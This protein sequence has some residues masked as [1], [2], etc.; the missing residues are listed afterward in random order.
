MFF[1]FFAFFTRSTVVVSVHFVNLEKINKW[2]STLIYESQCPNL[3]ENWKWIRK[4]KLLDRMCDIASSMSQRIVL[5]FPKFSG[6]PI[7]GK[8][9]RTLGRLCI[10]G[11]HRKIPWPSLPGLQAFPVPRGPTRTPAKFSGTIHIRLLRLGSVKVRS[12]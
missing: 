5:S 11:W 3:L 6:L 10:R 2:I 12:I 4:K 1:F 7:R 9:V 8:S